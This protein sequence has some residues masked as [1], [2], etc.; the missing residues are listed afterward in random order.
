[1]T[2]AL[3]LS[4]SVSIPAERVHGEL[5]RGTAPCSPAHFFGR[6]RGKGLGLD[7]GAAAAAAI[8]GKGSEVRAWAGHEER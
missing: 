4:L 1:M 5:P 3:S 6:G 7:C 2:A 8:C